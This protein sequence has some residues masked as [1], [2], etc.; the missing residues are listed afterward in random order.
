MRLRLRLRLRRTGERSWRRLL[1]ENLVHNV[2]LL[3][4]AGHDLSD[5]EREGAHDDLGRGFASLQE[6]S[7]ALDALLQLGIGERLSG[8]RHVLSG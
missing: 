1:L 3:D 8:I 7:G 5:A 2:R 6:G 4:A